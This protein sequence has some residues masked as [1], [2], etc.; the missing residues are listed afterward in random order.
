MHSKY[1]VLLTL[2]L[3]IGFGTA[4]LESLGTFKQNDA[5]RITQ[6]CSDATYINISSISYP[7]SSVAISGIEMT[8]SGNGEFYYNFNSATELGRYDV[9]GISDGCENTF[10]VY[11]DVTPNGEEKPDGI[12]IV[13]FTI[14][15]IGI[16]FFGLVA[17]FK[18]L[19]HVFVLDMDILDVL[20]LMGSY[21]SMWIFYVFER[22]YLGNSLIEGI[23]EIAI[24]VGAI[25]HVLM[26]LI[27]F[28]VSIILTNMKFKQ[29]QRVTY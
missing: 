16:F 20:T 7:N 10:A 8:S 29:K 11:F 3:L 18:S 15:F 6:V 22:Q 21:F 17:F 2:I 26:P 24:S 4:Q 5:I 19:E 23:T 27:S 14:L 12:V 9:R 28:F 13:I 25:T 1:L